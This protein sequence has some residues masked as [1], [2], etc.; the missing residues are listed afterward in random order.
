MRQRNPRR[1][2]C[3]DEPGSITSHEREHLA[4]TDKGIALLRRKLRQEI[5]KL[6]EGEEPLPPVPGN[7]GHVPTYGGDSILHVP[8]TVGDDTALILDLSRKVAEAYI[9]FQDLPDQARRDAIARRLA[10]LN[11]GDTE[12]VN[13]DH[14]KVFEFKTVERATSES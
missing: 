9:E 4:T 5:R 1:L 10:P 2:R 8:A 7:G 12:A 13:P 6:R 11:V 3:L 14:G